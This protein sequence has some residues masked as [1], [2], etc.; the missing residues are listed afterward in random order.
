MELNSLTLIELKALAYDQLSQLE[1][2]QNNLKIINNAI[3]QKQTQA[4]QQPPK[5]P[6]PTE[7]NE[8]EKST[9]ETVTT[10]E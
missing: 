10:G 7:A 3:Q 4:L 9:T 6:E 5:V 1:V 8:S 2:T